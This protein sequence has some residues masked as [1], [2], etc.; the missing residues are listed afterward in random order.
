M[1]IK[2]AVRYYLLYWKKMVTPTVSQDTGQLELSDT[3][4][5]MQRGT[6][7]LENYSAVSYT[8][9]ASLVAQMVKILSA[10]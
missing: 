5:K 9:K 2:T 8:C 3:D 4:D 1:Q 10:V 6:D 7:T